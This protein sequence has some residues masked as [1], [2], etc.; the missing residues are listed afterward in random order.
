MIYKPLIVL[1]NF[2]VG[3]CDQ[4]QKEKRR[5]EIS[6]RKGRE[7]KARKGKGREIFPTPWD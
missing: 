7:W 6:E 5:D 3:V 4:E 2:R 1:L